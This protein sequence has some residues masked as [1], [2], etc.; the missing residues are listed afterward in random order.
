MSEPVQSPREAYLGFVTE[1]GFFWGRPDHETVERLQTIAAD[2]RDAS[3]HF[4]AGYVLYQAIHSAWGDPETAN[5]C[6]V[7]ALSDFQTAAAR[8][9]DTDL[10]GIASL[11]MWTT[12][13]GLN[14]QGALHQP[15]V[16]LDSAGV[17]QHSQKPHQ[18]SPQGGF[19]SPT[20]ELC[21]FAAVKHP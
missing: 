11:Q 18:A 4:Y 5:A 19:W 20:L 15:L 7:A 16:S 6:V 10:E 3:Q 14:Y 17:S 2:W 9:E 1:G 12:L 13:I 21:R 8:A